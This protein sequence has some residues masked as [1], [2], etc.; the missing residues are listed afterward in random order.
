M[1]QFNKDC[2]VDN[3]G[4]KAVAAKGEVQ[5]GTTPPSYPVKCVECGEEFTAQL[6]SELQ[7]DSA[8]QT[9]AGEE[10]ESE[11]QETTSEDAGEQETEDTLGD[12]L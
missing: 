6:H 9:E 3:C 8:E 12:V 7:A 10:T 4:G 1:S 5:K 2:P 11:Q